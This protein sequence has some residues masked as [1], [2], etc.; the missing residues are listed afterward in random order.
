VPGAASPRNQSASRLPRAGLSGPCRRPHRACGRSSRCSRQFGSPRPAPARYR[1]NSGTL[2]A[3][4]RACQPG[5][6]LATQSPRSVAGLAASTPGTTGRARPV[7]AGPATNVGNWATFFC[8][9]GLGRDAPPC[10]QRYLSDALAN[11]V[12]IDPVPPPRIVRHHRRLSTSGD[13]RHRRCLGPAPVERRIAGSQSLR[14]F[15]AVRA[16]RSRGGRARRDFGKNSRASQSD[17]VGQT[18][19]RSPPLHAVRQDLGYDSSKTRPERQVPGAD[20]PPPSATSSRS[21]RSCPHVHPGQ[22]THDLSPPFEN[23]VPARGLARF[24]SCFVQD[25]ETGRPAGASR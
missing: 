7:A 20:S 23:A 2:T 14:K 16:P 19:S 22:P 8:C 4:G 18:R 3:V 15:R 11:G 12:P 10:Q 1:A 25:T 6:P 5:K 17:H 13:H 9:S 24:V 21:P